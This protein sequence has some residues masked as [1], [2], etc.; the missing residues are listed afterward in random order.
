MLLSFPHASRYVHHSTLK[1][2]A[3][4]R[5]LLGP[6]SSVDSLMFDSYHPSLSPSHT[7]P[8]VSNPR[9]WVII[10]PRLEHS[11]HRFLDRTD[12]PRFIYYLETQR[13][14]LHVLFAGVDY[15]ER[16]IHTAR[17]VVQCRAARSEGLEASEES[18]VDLS[19]KPHDLGNTL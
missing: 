19:T 8:L 7:L 6:R 17:V 11:R 13:P 10:N 1:V 18:N 12:V 15:Q 9:C 4:P 5:P 2:D 14:P 3:E 16:W